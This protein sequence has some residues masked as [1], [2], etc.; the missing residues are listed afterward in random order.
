MNRLTWAAFAAICTLPRF[1]AANDLTLEEAL[2][3][4]RDR[5]PTVLAARIRV[6]EARGRLDGAKPLLR[7]NPVVQGAAGRRLSERGSS[8]ELEL[9]LSQ[10][11]ELGG[12]RG[13]RIEAAEAGVAREVAASE[14]VLRRHLASVASAFLRTLHAQER[15]RLAT[16]AEMVAR[17][18]FDATERRHKA[19]D[20]PILDVNVAKAAWARAVSQVR[21]EEALQLAT[22][23]ELR[24]LLGA[25][26]EEPLQ[27][28]GDLRDRRR[29]EPHTL[30]AQ[31]PQRADV[32]ALGSEVREA[33]AERDLGTAFAWP[34]VGVGINYE[35][36]EGAH[37]L[38]GGLTLTLPLFSRG[39]ELRATGA[40]RKRRL[41]LE[42]EATRRAVSVEVRTA[43][44]AYAKRVEAVE[45]LEREAVPLLQENEALAR[46]SY[47]AG[48]LSL[49]DWLLIRREVV[50]TRV[51]YLDRLLDA[52]I[53]GVEVEASAGVLQ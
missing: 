53:A 26:P 39:Q 27:V 40:A 12:R 25:T 18:I 19:G 30:L 38:L 37:V 51:N 7:E 20:V 13:A 1:A 52:A 42:L 44:D 24:A 4:A 23:G 35:Q 5:A 14:D 46:R 6:D 32:R 9:G 22:L 31:A 2:S 10:T 3:L 43:L 17:G 48:Q 47:E 21:A 28:V 15:V 33:E 29:F 50:E 16:A 49:A 36:E 41:T 34:E 8:L 45:A 11:V